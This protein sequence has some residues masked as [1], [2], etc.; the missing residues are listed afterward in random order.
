VTVSRRPSATGS[1]LTR[2]L[3]IILCTMAVI[4]QLDA[5]QIIS[6]LISHAHPQMR[7]NV[8]LLSRFLIGLYANSLRIHSYP[9]RSKIKFGCGSWKRIAS[10]PKKVHIHFIIG[11][12]I[13]NE[14]LHRISIYCF[15]IQSRLRVCPNL[16]EG[17]WRCIMGKRYQKVLFRQL[18][19]AYEY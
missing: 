15:R 7:K 11:H 19:R 1:R 14:S 16:C 18:R 3:I 5:F 2:S 12:I 9:S 8:R 6:Y 17:A 10:S 13:N 4:P